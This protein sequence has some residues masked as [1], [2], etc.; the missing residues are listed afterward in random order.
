MALGVTVINKGKLFGSELAYVVR[1]QPDNSYPTG[2]YALT[3]GLV[4]LNVIDALIPEPGI[5]GHDVVLDRTANKVKWMAG[6]A[7]AGTGT[8][9]TAAVDLST[10]QAVTCIVLGH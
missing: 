9:V 4:G 8:E 10:Q 1:L 6:A 2:G 7:A 3:P 5:N